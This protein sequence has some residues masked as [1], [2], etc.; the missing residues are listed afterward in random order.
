VR[1]VAVGPEGW[2][3]M[4]MTQQYLAGEL[5]VLLS[6]LQAVASNR[7]FAGDVAGLRREAETVPVTTLASV[8]ARAMRLTDGLCWES[9]SRGDVAA[10]NRQAAVSAEL[11]EFGVCSGLLDEG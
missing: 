9:V 11:Y 8:A 3:A 1:V 4:V 7:V 10:F 6:Q 2:A 5:S